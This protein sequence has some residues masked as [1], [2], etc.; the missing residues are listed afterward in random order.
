[1][2]RHR[3]WTD[4]LTAGDRSHLPQ[5]AGTVTFA[6]VAERH[7]GGALGY[8]A[9]A[10]WSAVAN[11]PGESGRLAPQVRRDERDGVN[12]CFEVVVLGV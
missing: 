8:A 12:G 9:S 5:Y 1:M 2:T 4:L 7:F 6:N 10:H 3:P 11:L